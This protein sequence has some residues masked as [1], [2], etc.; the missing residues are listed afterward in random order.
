[1]GEIKNV[2][3]IDGPQSLAAAFGE[4][5]CEVLRLAG[6]GGSVLDLGQALAQ[7]REGRGFEP[8]L[9]V[10]A[11]S[12]GPRCLLA[13]LDALACPTMLWCMDPHLNG[14][15]HAPY[16]RLFDLTCSS[17]RAAIPVLAGRGAADVRWLPT[18]GLRSPNPAHGQRTRD[19]AFVGR[20]TAAR[21]GRTWMV[22]LLERACAGHVLTVT[23]GLSF[24]A[25]LD[26]YRDARIVPN[27][28]ILGEVNFRLFEGASCGCLVLGQDLG[29]EQAALFE[30]GREFDTYA[31][32]VELEEKLC[33]YLKN[34]RLTQAMGRAGRERVLAEHTVR[35][36]AQRL[37][38]YGR[39]AADCRARGRE[40]DTWLALTVAAM[41]EADMFGGSAQEVLARMAG[42]PGAIDLTVSPEVACAAMRVQA[43]AG[44]TTA[45]GVAV[46][47][48][49]A[50]GLW[51]D[52]A[53]ANLTGSMAALRLDRFD[54]AKSFWYRHIRS[55]GIRNPGPP[56]SPDDLCILWARDAARRGTVVRAG[57]TFDPATH[58]PAAASECLLAVLAHRPEDPAVT[59]LLDTMFRPLPGFSQLRVG[60]LSSLTLRER[61][62]WRLA[63]ELAL[64]NLRSCR[65]K[66]GLEEL[67]VARKLAESQGQERAFARALAAGDRSGMVAVRFKR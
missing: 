5:G 1:M 51:E 21:P 54:A 16:A 30:P 59:R 48:L 52:S 57:F 50:A 64:A 33:M 14:Y 27:E 23:D 34:P 61:D 31:D 47:S 32:G 3:L 24:K 43:M 63:L 40:A 35:H 20:L 55:T 8:D 36:R 49:L 44:M 28:S 62:D 7:A 10:Q 60:L 58:L 53:E 46:D 2:C 11:E 12:L 66:S 37:L 15:W 56:G 26:L 19:A 9:V 67:A 25:M 39:D 6:S 65:V 13:G 18:Y 42:G 22:R 17:Q 41:W 38:E 29:D 45:L 4:L